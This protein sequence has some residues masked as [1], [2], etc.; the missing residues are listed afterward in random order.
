MW[1]ICQRAS[2]TKEQ[3]VKQQGKAYLFWDEQAVH[4]VH[5]PESYSGR[6]Y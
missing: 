3:Q 1:L 6:H 5:G 4:D 2:A